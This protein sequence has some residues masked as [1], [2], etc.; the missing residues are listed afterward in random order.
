MTNKEVF[1]IVLALREEKS[2][3]DK[4]N[5]I[6]YMPDVSEEPKTWHGI[7]VF[8]LADRPD[9]EEQ[10]KVDGITQYCLGCIPAPGACQNHYDEYGWSEWEP[11]DNSYGENT[12]EYSLLCALFEFAYYRYS[13]RN[14]D[15][16]EIRED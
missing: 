1:D 11:F 13:G 15:E 4:T 7:Q 2:V 10:I 5:N 14:A 12:S 16:I 6:L 8:Y 9:L 3:Y